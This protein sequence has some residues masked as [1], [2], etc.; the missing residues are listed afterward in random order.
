MICLGRSRAAADQQ[1]LRRRAETEMMNTVQSISESD[2]FLLFKTR[3]S[4][5]F[6]GDIRQYTGKKEIHWLGNMTDLIICL[7]IAPQETK[8]K[9]EGERKGD[10]SFSPQ[11]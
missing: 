11:I 2:D 4:V 1:H 5:V 10:L 3:R 6:S 7:D 8:A 9:T